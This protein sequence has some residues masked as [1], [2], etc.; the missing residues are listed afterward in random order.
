MLLSLLGLRS[1]TS[2]VISGMAQKFTLDASPP[3]NRWMNHTLVKDAFRKSLLVLAAR[4]PP[5]KTGTLLK[6]KAM[7]KYIGVYALR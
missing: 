2:I 1:Q 6:A 3:A 5:A 7:K 4:V